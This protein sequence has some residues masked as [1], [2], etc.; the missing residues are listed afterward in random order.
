[1]DLKPYTYTVV[2]ARCPASTPV[3]GSGELGP[4]KR[5]TACLLHNEPVSYFVRLAKFLWNGAAAKASA[6]R[7]TL[8]HGVDPK[9]RRSNHGQVEADLTVRGGPNRLTLKSYR[10][11]CG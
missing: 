5:V 6:K 9:R 2:G 10:M 8:S 7:A 4:E 1:M 3:F 11:T